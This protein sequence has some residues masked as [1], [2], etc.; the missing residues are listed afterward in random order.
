[1]KLPGTLLVLLLA[2]W[3]YSQKE[4]DLMRDSLILE[5]GEEAKVVFLAK[6]RKAFEEIAKYDLNILYLN[7][8]SQLL[9]GKK[10]AV[11]EISDQEAE[12]YKNERYDGPATVRKQFWKR[13]H[14][15]VFLGFSAGGLTEHLFQSST[16]ELNDPPGGKLEVYNTA[17]VS[18]RPKLSY[19]LSLNTKFPLIAQ[20][21]RLLQLSTSIGLD[22]LKF[23]QKSNNSGGIF[24]YE[25]NGSPP[26]LSGI[27]ALVDSLNR[28]KP[29][30][31][32]ANATAINQLYLQFMPT[33][34]FMDKEGRPTWN[35]GLGVRGGIDLKNVLGPELEVAE[36]LVFSNDKLVISENKAFQ[37]GLVSTL[38]YKF[39]NVFCNYI[40]EAHS[41]IE[42][43]G[44]ARPDR[45]GRFLR[46]IWFIGLRLGK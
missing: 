5:I 19:G 39:L 28:Q 1:M 34:T 18:T 32:F 24:F 7:L 6:N 22:I 31:T 20:G 8:W 10:E 17:R 26:Q 41:I 46:G 2:N 36:P 11:S 43:D 25:G 16:Y 45:T 38:G 15:N 12:K 27:Q 4:A 44:L 33:F 14:I 40:P 23:N 35:I 29:I 21:N 9:D 13:F 37:Y 42:F 30:G 3:G